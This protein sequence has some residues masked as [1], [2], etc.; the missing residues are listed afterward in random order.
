[1]RTPL[2]VRKKLRIAEVNLRQVR[3]RFE[4]YDNHED[5][6]LIPVLIQEIETLKWVLNEQQPKKK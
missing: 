1:M 2:D 3:A 4:E 5:M 6:E